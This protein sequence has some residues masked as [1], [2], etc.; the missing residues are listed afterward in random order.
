MTFPPIRKPFRKSPWPSWWNKLIAPVISLAVEIGMR[1]G[2]ILAIKANDIDAKNRCLLI[3]H[4]K[5]GHARTIALSSKALAVG[6]AGE[7][8]LFPL[9]ANAFRLAWERVKARA[10]ID[11]LH[12]HDLRH[13]AIIGTET[14][15]AWSFRRSP[16][17]FWSVSWFD[18]RTVSSSRPALAQ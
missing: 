7:D 18:L 17:S 12:F 11:D 14:E 10:G 9:T 1:R 4:T 2:E 5:N 15:E 8:R 16:T 3:P 6:R 13:E